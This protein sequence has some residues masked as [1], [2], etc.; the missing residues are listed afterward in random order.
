MMT[1]LQ[2]KVICSN[3][4]RALLGKKNP[5]LLCGFAKS[6]NTWLRAFI[7]HYYGIKKWDITE[8]FTF[9]EMNYQLSPNLIGLVAPI[10]V[11]DGIPFIYRSHTKY[12]KCYDLFKMIYIWRNPLDTLISYW[13]MMKDMDVPFFRWD[14]DIRE[15]LYDIDF[16]VRLEIP[17]WVEHIKTTKDKARLILNYDELRQNPYIFESVIRL[18]S[19]EVD[20][21]VL[22]RAIELSSFNRMK[23]MSIDSNQ[24]FGNVIR[25]G[26]WF[27]GI[28]MRNG[29]TGQWDKE[30]K[31]D[32][33][34]YINK[35][36][37][38]MNYE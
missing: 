21:T 4:E 25:G 17:K 12:L 15:Y 9:N 33:I 6:G 35:K 23:K 20:R 7:L 8:P 13:Y 10:S 29:N 22:D 11:P 30:L 32:T 3:I 14:E 5:I 16:F 1:D 28:F 24:E 26:S 37:A 27:H 34:E 19:K 38:E 2:R 31:K 36:V 18:I